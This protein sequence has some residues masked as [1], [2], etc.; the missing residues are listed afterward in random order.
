MIVKAL[1]LALWSVSVEGMEEIVRCF[2]DY[3][4][5]GNNARGVMFVRVIIV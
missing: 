3:C 5:P 2:A 1:L 4:G